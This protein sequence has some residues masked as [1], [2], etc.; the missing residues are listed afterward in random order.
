MADNLFSA[1]PTGSIPAT[2]AEDIVAIGGQVRTPLVATWPARCVVCNGD[3][4]AADY[5]TKLVWYPRWTILVFLFSRLIGLILMMVKRKTATLHLGLCEEH[6]ATRR[7]RL[8]AFGGTFLASFASFPL[9]GALDTVWIMIAGIVAFWV[10]LIGL[11]VYAKP[12]RMARVEGD[13]GYVKAK[14]AFVQSL[15]QGY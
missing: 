7:T 6:R 4:P 12:V 14:P 1:L 15:P 9:A 11:I 5:K 8:W 10:G 2:G 13:Y 3:V